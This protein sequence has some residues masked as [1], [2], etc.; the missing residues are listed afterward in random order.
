MRSL[1]IRIFASFWLIIVIT[2]IAAAAIGFSYAERT[3]ITL[4]NF[5]LNEAV[6]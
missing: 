2:I 6:L 1:L 5:E 4:Q 3:R